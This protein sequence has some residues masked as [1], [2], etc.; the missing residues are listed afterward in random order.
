ML[1]KSKLKLKSI[2]YD[3]YG[4]KKGLLRYLWHWCL[5]KLG[6]YRHY[7]GVTPGA[8]Q[9]VVF[10]CSGNICRSPLGEYYARSLGLE[11]DS[12]GLDCGVGFPADPRAVQY[13][14]QVNLDLDAHQTKRVDEFPF[15]PDDLI[16]VMEPKHV[17]KFHQQV[18]TKHK[19]VLA[20]L[21][22]PKPFPYLHDPYNCSPQYFE[23]CEALVMSSVRGLCAKN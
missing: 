19:I 6:A 20:G 16:V 3:R 7:Q 18:G 11:T 8:G 5:A 10:I 12:C 21:C 23:R 2:I 17:R 22:C 1:K 4:S 9:R 15:R 13:G 14:R